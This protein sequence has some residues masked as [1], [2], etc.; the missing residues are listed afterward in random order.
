MSPRRTASGALLACGLVV[1]ACTTGG[2]G[3]REPDPVVAFDP[4][5]AAATVRVESRDIYQTVRLEG[6]LET[7]DPVTVTAPK[8]GRF[9]PARGLRDGQAVAAE[10]TL[11]VVHCPPAVA[12]PQPGS[13]TTTTTPNAQCPK[14]GTPVRSPVAGVVS[15]L[16]EQDVPATG[17]VATVQPPGFHA[18]L[19]VSDPA[20]LYRFTTPPKTGKAELVGGPSGIVVEYETQVYDKGSGQTSV[21][22]RVPGDVQAFAGLRVVVVFVTGVKD[23]VPTLPRSA[24]RG[25]AGRGEV[26]AV[27][28]A[29]VRTRL[30]VTLGDADDEHVEVHGVDPAADILRFPLESDFDG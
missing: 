11:G 18:K 17:P 9:A 20:V 5:P 27:D 2:S 24:V 1:T 7:Y 15:G 13:T 23:G 10:A 22:A 8:A 19:P 14:A 12:D 29:G 3:A 25:Q 4:G 6:V 30:A 26:V 28:P 16:L 21:Y